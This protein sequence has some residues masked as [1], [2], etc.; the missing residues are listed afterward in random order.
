MGKYDDIGGVWRTIGGR[1]VFIK[2]GQ[3]L[4][5][6]MIESGKFK[7]LRSNYKKAKEEDEKAKQ[8]K[9]WEEK[10]KKLEKENAKNKGYEL[11][12]N[13][14]EEQERQALR[15]GDMS[16][17]YSKK[18]LENI[19]NKEL[20]DY[21]NRQQELV[22]E[23]T[24]KVNQDLTYDQRKTRNRQDTI[25]DR[26]MKT[27]YEQQ[28]K[29]AQEEKTRREEYVNKYFKKENGY[30]TYLK[31]TQGTTNEELINVGREKENKVDYQKY[32]D[33]VIR[34]INKKRMEKGTTNL[35]QAYKKA[36]EEYKKLHPNTKLNLQD[37]IKMSEE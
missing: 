31:D 26:G 6:A 34:N 8:N 13:Y 10:V 14:Y 19:S 27:K 1:R 5:S 7:N 11:D 22:D 23:Y 24:N 16:Y 9:E 3:S 20:E 28:L 15:S 18:A 30:E 36:F 17:G 35:N 25:W 12:E 2:D 33:E 29:N 21:I 37:F 4:S 32:K